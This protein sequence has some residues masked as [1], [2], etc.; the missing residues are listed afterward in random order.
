MEN[1]GKIAS[2]EDY[3]LGELVLGKDGPF[4]HQNRRYT[5]RRI[6]IPEKPNLEMLGGIVITAMEEVRYS[7]LVE[8]VHPERVVVEAFGS[9]GAILTRAE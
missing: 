4:V 2:M 6:R 3:Y 9:T 7:T 1:Y 8:G 5:F